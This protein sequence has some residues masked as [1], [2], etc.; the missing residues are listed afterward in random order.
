ML[1]FKA[2][3]LFVA[4]TAAIGCGISAFGRDTTNLI[5]PTQAIER[6]AAL[7]ETGI[8]GVFSMTVKRVD[9]V[10]HTYFLDSEPDYRDQRNLAVAV[11]QEAAKDLE[12]Q[13][14]ASLKSALKGKQI[15]V[16]GTAKRVKIDFAHRDQPTG[17]YYY[18]THIDVKS[19]S[20][21]TVR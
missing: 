1:R 19:A 17:K 11:S 8:T 5:E 15:V 12:E 14:G 7:P 9:K 4:T 13:L 16:S 2:L 20:Q 3:T 10:G 6:A 18:Q 21:V